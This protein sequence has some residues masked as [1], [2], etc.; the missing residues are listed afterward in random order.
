MI[1]I[2]HLF[3]I[4]APKEEVFK[5]LT[6]LEGLAGWWTNNTNGDSSIGGTIQFRFGDYGGPDM[7]VKEIV[8]NESVTWECVGENDGWLGHLFTF[9]LDTNDNKTRLRFEQSGWE[10]SGDFYASCNF[11]W[12]RYL[13]SLRQLC[14]TG[15]GEAFGSEGYRK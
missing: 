8:P 7:K 3:H 9:Q 13:E 10:E 6:T 15:K 4:N 14:Q 2:K 5:A 1:L 11:S 12:G